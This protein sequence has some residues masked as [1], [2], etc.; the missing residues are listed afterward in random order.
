MITLIHRHSL[1]PREMTAFAVIDFNPRAHNLM[2]MHCANVIEAL[3]FDATFE[4]LDNDPEQFAKWALT[5]QED[6][7]WGPYSSCHT[8]DMGLTDFKFLLKLREMSL[9]VR[10]RRHTLQF[11][12]GFH[13]QQCL[14]NDG[15][16]LTVMTR[17]R[18]ALGSGE[19]S[20]I[21]YDLYKDLDAGIVY[22]P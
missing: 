3:N 20:G 19:G 11:L 17:D 4:L 15:A 13:I 22:F 8:P 7:D 2:S 14:K 21:V 10:E 16:I 9:L 12:R 5:P 6:K 1:N 18:Y